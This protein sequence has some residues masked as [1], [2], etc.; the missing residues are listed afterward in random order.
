MMCMQADTQAAKE[1]LAVAEKASGFG[2]A[3]E[4]TSK[5]RE[6]GPSVS[7]SACCELST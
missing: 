5:G 7:R 1:L 3:M 2:Q 4:S 6:S